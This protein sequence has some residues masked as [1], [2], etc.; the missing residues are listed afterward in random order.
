MSLR[1]WP[2]LPGR[3]A[4]IGY[5]VGPQCRQR[6]DVAA[7][8]HAVSRWGLSLAG[9]AQSLLETKCGAGWLL[10]FVRAGLG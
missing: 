1:A 3:R 6:G 2:N 8:L 4:S 5:W 9:I 10:L 7:A